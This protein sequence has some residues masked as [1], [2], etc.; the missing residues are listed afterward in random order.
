[1]LVSRTFLRLEKVIQT[2]I[3]III[4]ILIISCGGKA[5][6][7]SSSSSSS[8]SSNSSSSSGQPIGLKERPVSDT[9]VAGD[10]P[11]SGSFELVNV[12]PRVRFGQPIGLVQMP[13][14]ASNDFYV[15]EKGG[16]ILRL[17]SDLNATTSSV[18]LDLR[19]VVETGGEGGVLSMAFHPDYPEQPYVYVSH[20]VDENGFISRISRFTTVDGLSASQEKILFNLPQSLSPYGQGSI[21]NAGTL[22]FGPDGYLYMSVGDDKR[23]F[24]A[25]DPQEL[26]GTIIRI[27]V[28]TEDSA[29]NIPNDNPF[30][31]EV[32]AYGFRNP[33]RLSFDKSTGDLW[34]GDVGE[35]CFEEVNKVAL[36]RNYGWP[37]WEG[38][39]CGL[40]E[41]NGD[42]TLPLHQY[43]TLEGC[44]PGNSIT[45][46][47]VYRGHLNS[48]LTGKYI[49]A[50]YQTGQVW[51]YDE[52][53]GFNEDLFV[54]GRAQ[55]IAAF[56]EDNQGEIFHIDIVAGAISR[57]EPGQGGATS[58]PPNR[59]S[60]TGCFETLAQDLVPA[61]GV[62][63]YEIAQPF[64]S[65]G[66]EKER[67]V[68]IPDNSTFVVDDEGDWELPIGG[69]LIKNFKWLG[70]NFETRFFV[71]YNNGAYG[72][73]TYE[74]TGESEAELVR[75]TGKSVK[76]SDGHVWQYPSRNECRQCHTVRAGYI[77]GPETRQM[78][79]NRYYPQTQQ[80]ANQFETFKALGMLSGNT[81]SLEPFPQVG[82][83]TSSLHE[84]AMAYLH[85]N[86][87]SC[88]RGAG[89]A[90]SIWDA[91]YIVP[92][93]DKGLCNI[94]PITPVTE[95]VQEY[96]V[97]PGDHTSSS[98]WWR[99]HQRGQ[100][101]MP[102]LASSIVDQAG[103]DLIAQWIDSLTISEC[104]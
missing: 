39:I 26:Y 32:Y 10:A 1:M 24:T 27:D 6:T 72:A 38:D 15:M 62:V 59:L 95:F 22:A 76:L 31:N 7:A 30:Q 53:N 100:G 73:Y 48:A 67:F 36:G 97:N 40:G 11:S 55:G 102:P 56:G 47:Y 41:C 90:Q 25:G 35:E 99:T 69:V 70:Q 12:W 51:A 89:G 3:F 43:H 54:E 19:N 96:Y 52:Q 21:H 75:A 86:C 58:G 60:E 82:S 44:G 104:Q 63:S 80:N 84:K 94:T 87:A 17:S 28:N 79:I 8:S 66:A 83:T 85:V 92:F 16:R 98:I 5:D 71:R 23:T 50:D 13:G 78:N 20:M 93:K 9:C 37:N 46:G 68:S 34:V 33:W 45:G 49:Y 29:Y 57:I 61:S 14:D 42:N 18:F 88:H 65:D 101:Q 103:V 4:Q 77:L 74:W 91:R 81:S 2:L 64:W